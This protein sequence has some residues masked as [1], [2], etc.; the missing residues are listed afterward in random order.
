[1][2]CICAYI[3]QW[4]KHT[5]SSA[6]VYHPN[7][8]QSTMKY[9]EQTKNAEHT[10]SLPYFME[11]KRMCQDICDICELFEHLFDKNDKRIIHTETH[12]EWL[13]CLSSL[14]LSIVHITSH[15]IPSHVHDQTQHLT[16]LYSENW[17]LTQSD[18][19]A[20]IRVYRKVLL[21]L[22]ELNRLDLYKWSNCMEFEAVKR[23]YV[24]DMFWMQCH[25][26]PS[27]SLWP[28]T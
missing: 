23:S 2:N 27:S 21:L 18:I 6:N 1:M 19:T 16:E 25:I 13:W 24:V 3:F 9:W 12:R 20:Y 17:E 14:R 15:H 28:G 11:E 7:K 26:F 8:S 10:I 4:I 22:F 5:H